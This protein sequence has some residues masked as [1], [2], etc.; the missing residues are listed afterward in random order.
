MDWEKAVAEKTEMM[1]R[2]VQDL[3]ENERSVLVWLLSAERRDRDK[4]R[5]RI[6][7]ELK[8]RLERVIRE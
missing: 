7:A 8:E 1:R 6:Q 3:S 2:I 5:P 4:P